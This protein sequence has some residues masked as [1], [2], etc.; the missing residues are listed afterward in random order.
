MLFPADF[1]ASMKETEC[2]TTKASIHHEHKNNIT[3]ITCKHKNLKPLLV[4]FYDPCLEMVKA[5][6]LWLLQHTQGL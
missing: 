2:N 1:L 4:T 3:Q 6:F 5:L